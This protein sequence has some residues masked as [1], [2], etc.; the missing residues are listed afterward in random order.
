MNQD[1]QVDGDKDHVIYNSNI[2]HFSG[3]DNHREGAAARQEHDRR[4]HR[5]ERRRRKLIVHLQQRLPY[6]GRSV[7]QDSNTR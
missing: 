7:N 5:Q 3:D 1:G 2:C 6:D 4:R